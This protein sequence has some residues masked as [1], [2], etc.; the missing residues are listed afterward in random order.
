MW[1]ISVWECGLWVKIFFMN[2]SL[3]SPVNKHC[4]VLIFPHWKMTTLRTIIK[5]LWV[6][7][8]V[9]ICMY[10]CMCEWLVCMWDETDFMFKSILLRNVEWIEV[11]ILYK[12]PDCTAN[13][14][15][16]LV[17]I[18]TVV[19]IKNF[20][21]CSWNSHQTRVILFIFDYLFM[22]LFIL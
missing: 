21:S 12:L 7:V 6:S 15:Y 3:I 16:K 4:R 19:E 22:Y 5:V 2:E 10:V 9:K 1:R 14:S 11:L 20:W 8:F 13:M 17:K 18:G